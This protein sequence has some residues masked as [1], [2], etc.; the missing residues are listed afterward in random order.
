MGKTVLK[1]LSLLFAVGVLTLLTM[2]A[3]P[4]LAAHGADLALRAFPSRLTC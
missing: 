2:A 1:A 4:F 3:A